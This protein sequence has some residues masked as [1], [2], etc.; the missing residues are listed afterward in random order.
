MRKKTITTVI[1]IISILFI[2]LTAARAGDYPSGT[3][4][5]GP[6]DLT[7]DHSEIIL[8]A[9]ARYESDFDESI[10]H[11]LKAESDNT[12][13][14]LDD[15][16]DNKESYM[17]IEDIG[18][19]VLS[20]YIIDPLNSWTDKSSLTAAGKELISGTIQLSMPVI[21]E[22][23]VGSALGSGHFDGTQVATSIAGAFVGSMISN[24]AGD[25]LEINTEVQQGGAVVSLSYRF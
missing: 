21:A 16:E 11:Y 9:T 1:S 19:I 3:S 7:A 18:N 14:D 20:R 17:E 6:I 12:A 10:N 13:D 5:Q 24:M 4:G 23:A 2:F 15:T 25:K 8:L 22:G